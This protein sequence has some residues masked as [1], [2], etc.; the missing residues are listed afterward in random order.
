MTFTS[1]D[2]TRYVSDCKRLLQE[3]LVYHIAADHAAKFSRFGGVDVYTSDAELPPVVGLDKPR[4]IIS[5]AEDNVDMTVFGST[6]YQHMGEH[7]RMRIDIDGW[8]GKKCGG[9]VTCDDL[10]AAVQRTLASHATELET[11]GM[12]MI[13]KSGSRE[14]TA[15]EGES[16][17]FTVTAEM[18]V[19]VMG[20]ILRTIEVEMGRW[21]FSGQG[22]GTFTDGSE[23][24]VSAVLRIKLITGTGSNTSEVTVYGTNQD[25]DAS[26]LTATIPTSR[27]AGT[28]VSLTPATAEDTFTDVTNVTVGQNSG[29]PGEVF[30]IVN[31]PEEL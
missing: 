9:R 2:S 18:D 21:T 31:V 15:Q 27:S 30:T 13:S 29:L 8:T 5:L 1:I 10:S 23:I 16:F 3:F 28:Y 11:A 7:H 19:D 12:L 6:Y 25:G 17:G 20:D 4:I 22:Q 26:T 14:L 24:P